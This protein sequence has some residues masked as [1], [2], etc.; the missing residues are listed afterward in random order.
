MKQSDKNQKKKVWKI[1]ANVKN[2][3]LVL[4][5]QKLLH[6]IYL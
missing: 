3:S 5:L 1:N 4:N 2:A 6:F